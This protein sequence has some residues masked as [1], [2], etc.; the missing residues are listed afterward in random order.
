MELKLTKH[1]ESVWKKIQTTKRLAAE[2]QIHAAIR[3]LL[4]GEFECAVTLALAAE[5]QL[6]DTSEPTLWNV[7]KQQVVPSDMRVF[8][9]LR[10]W[11]K[12]GSGKDAREIS[13]LEVAI[14]LIRATTRYFAVFKF[15]TDEMRAFVKWC[16]DKGRFALS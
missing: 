14:A 13:E 11:L 3:H 16:T 9:D 1:D 15:E 2:R 7:L 4:S 12:H 5:D 8:N 6:P 10:D